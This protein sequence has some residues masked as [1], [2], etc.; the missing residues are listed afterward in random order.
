MKQPVRFLQRHKYEILLLALMQHLFVGIVLSDLTFYSR[1][2][3]PINMLLLGVAGT[4]VFMGKAGWRNTLRS[5]LFLLVF[6]MSVFLPFV[7]ASPD[8]Q[9][10]LSLID[11]VFFSFL[12][13]EIMRFLIR[14]GYIN[15]DVI[16]ASVC[17][18]LLLIEISVFL[19]Q[20][21]LY[22]NPLCYRGVEKSSHA[23]M[24][25]DLVYFCTITLT[26]IGFG[27]ITA[28]THYTKLITALLGITGQFYVVILVG[29]LISKFSSKTTP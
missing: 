22:H 15:A 7:I 26:S 8:L 18:Y 11:F 24:F 29:I 9:A 3:W 17:G 19:N 2:I 25:I 12:L 14:P 1:V 28:D 10:T 6:L 27:D 4:G 5:F 16:S 23:A 20:F 21:L 13:W